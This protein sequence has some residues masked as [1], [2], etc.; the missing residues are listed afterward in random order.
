MTDTLAK[1]ASFKAGSFW[2]GT[3][4]LS[5]VAQTLKSS[6]VPLSGPAATP[7]GELL[8][9]MTKLYYDAYNNGY[10]NRQLFNAER[11]TLAEHKPLLLPL[12]HNPLS[13]RK[14][15]DSLIR[16]VCRRT[17]DDDERA[18]KSEA[19]FMLED[20]TTAVVAY[21][22]EQEAARLAQVEP[23]SAALPLSS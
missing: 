5:Q 16:D 1:D 18:E 15:L 4:P 10:C 23:H 8:R 19:A 11:A 17:D 22:A 20:I 14:D 12:L 6:L 9:C 3:H 2:A 13:W 21:V 7:H